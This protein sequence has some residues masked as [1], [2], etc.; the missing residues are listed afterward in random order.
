M[1]WEKYNPN[2][3]GRSVGDCAVRAVAKALHVTWG[4]AYAMIAA[5]GFAMADMPSSNGV[6]GS[7]LRD[8]SG[9]SYRWRGGNSYSRGRGQSAQR[10]SMGRYSGAA[11]PSELVDQIMGMMQDAPNSQIKQ[12]MQQLVEQ[13]EQM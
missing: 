12:Q 5:N 7:V 10:D 8:M 11:E 6:W 9:N 4:E 1:A 2:P 3:A 13:L